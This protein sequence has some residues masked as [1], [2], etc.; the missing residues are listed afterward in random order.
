M[1]V[2]KFTDSRAS[3]RLS[4]VSTSK[5]YPVIAVGGGPAGIA[6]AIECIEQGVDRSDVLVLEKGEA[7]IKAIQ[8]FYPD[9]KMTLPNYKNL[10][11][12]THGNIPAFKDLTK[13]ETVDYFQELIDRYQIQYRL[14]SEVSKVKKRED[15]VIELLVNQEIITADQVTIGIGIL[16]RPR[17]PEYKIP[18]KLR[19]KVFFDLTTEPI[20]EGKI[21]VVGGGDTSAEYCD[22]LVSEGCEVTLAYRSAEF[23]RMMESNRKTVERLLAEN[24]LRVQTQCVIADLEEDGERCKVIYDEACDYGESDVF[25]KIVFAI[26]GTTPVNFLKTIGIEFDENKWP[27]TNENGET[28]IEGVYLVGD[29][30]SGRTGG[31]IITSYNSCFKTVQKIVSQLSKLGRKLGS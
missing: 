5:H 11:T 3:V 28:N 21:L 13:K 31:S 26:G 24:K 7:I 12:E 23:K 16:G 30:M 27:K 25:D 1:S 19:K 29:L 2:K 20:T 10:P 15:G 14:N 18:L 8:Q 22:L 4:I 17:K 9:K 6:V